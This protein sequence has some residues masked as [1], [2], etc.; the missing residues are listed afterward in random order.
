MPQR[1]YFNPIMIRL[2]NCLARRYAATTGARRLIPPAP[3][4]YDST[5]N[6]ILRPMYGRDK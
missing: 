4:R 6:S 5:K 1:N 2:E 3:A